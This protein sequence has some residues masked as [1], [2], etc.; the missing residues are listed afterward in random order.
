MVLRVARMAFL[1]VDETVDVIDDLQIVRL[2]FTSASALRRFDDSA[3]GG[4][5]FLAGRFGRAGDDGSLLA[6]A[7]GE[8]GDEFLIRFL[9]SHHPSFEPAIW[10]RFVTSSSETPSNGEL[11]GSDSSPGRLLLPSG[12]QILPNPGSGLSQHCFQPGKAVSRDRRCGA[13]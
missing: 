3:V 7:V 5:G 13:G 11:V 4:I 10:R 12:C 2:A 6:V 9:Q 8:E 1:A